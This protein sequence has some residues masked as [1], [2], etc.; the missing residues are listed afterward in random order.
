MV[1]TVSPSSD[2]Q[3]DFDVVLDVAKQQLPTGSAA[4]ELLQ[5]ITTALGR[6]AGVALVEQDTHLTPNQAAALIGI[7]RPHLLTFMNAGALAFT[8]F[9]SHR[10]IKVSDLLELNARRQDARTLVSQARANASA[11]EA[12]HLDDAAPLSSD[13]L[14]ELD[15]L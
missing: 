4:L 8:R 7:S 3:H 1:T 15:S 14:T 6:G 9:G 13:T 10:R 2:V 5:S 12:R 11:S